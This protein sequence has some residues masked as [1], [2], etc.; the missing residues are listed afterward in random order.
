MK[1]LLSTF[2]ALIGFNI[3]VWNSVL[4]AAPAAD[5]L[6]LYFLDVGQGDS[7]LIKLPGEDGRSVKIMIDGGSGKQTLSSLYNALPAT[8]RYVD[9]LILTHP[10]LD[11]FGGFID[12]LKRF[13]VG[14]FIHNGREGTSAGWK[15]LKRL[16]KDKHIKTVVLKEGDI[17]NYQNSNLKFLS[18]N[19]KFL[20]SK[21]LNDT[22]LVAVL[23]SEGSKTL[24]TADIGFKDM[25]VEEYLIKK[26]SNEINA[27]ILKIAHHGSKFSSS[28]QFI[29]A[30]SPEV[31]IVSAGERNRYGH[32]TK[33]ALSR[34]ASID[35]SL[36][37]TDEDG[38][39][40]LRVKD[41]IIE[42]L[43]AKI[44]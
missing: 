19:D 25:N 6:N 11:H 14:A 43:K 32:P 42:V 1:F 44:D 33:E 37:R 18:P 30:V 3:F 15:E 13:E 35:D 22:P 5:R 20:K 9:L 39:V 10:Q 8:E 26:Y 38:T 16:L 24:F 40:H 28:S 21:E 29:R 12:V 2:L 7:A 23:E 41:G 4:S 31:S 36:Y 27:D 17:I 34:V